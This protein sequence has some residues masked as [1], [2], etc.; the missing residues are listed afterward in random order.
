MLS[1]MFRT[2]EQDAELDERLARSRWGERDEHAHARGA[3]PSEAH[4]EIE[5]LRARWRSALDDVER[6]R[7][8]VADLEAVNRDLTGRLMEAQLAPPGPSAR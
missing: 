1:P 7:A 3:S 4:L 5:R 6:L 2:P 8:R